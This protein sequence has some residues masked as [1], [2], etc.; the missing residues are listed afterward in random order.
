MQLRDK[1]RETFKTVPV[2]SKQNST[3][4]SRENNLVL[5]EEYI[6]SQKKFSKYK[7]EIKATKGKSR[8]TRVGNTI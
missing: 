7:R 1:E 5:F 6:S 4:R 8:K 3:L 2:A